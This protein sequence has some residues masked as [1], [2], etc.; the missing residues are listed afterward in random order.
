MHIASRYGC[1]EIVRFL[2]EFGANLDIED[3]QHD[4]CIHV[5]R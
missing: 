2:C 5:A 1:C 4:T 3:D